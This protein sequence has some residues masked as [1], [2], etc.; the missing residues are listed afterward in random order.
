MGISEQESSLDE[1]VKI[2][3]EDFFELKK[4]MKTNK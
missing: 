2:K 1:I 3:E 4:G